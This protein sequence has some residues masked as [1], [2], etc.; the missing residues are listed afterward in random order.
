MTLVFIVINFLLL[1]VIGFFHLYWGFGG[2]WPGRDEPSLAKAVIGSNG[3]TAMP[4]RAITLIVSACLFLASIWPLI[5]LGLIETPLPL[6]IRELG[7][8]GLIVVFIGRGIAG[9]VPSFRRKNSELPFANYDRQYYSPLCFMIGVFFG[10][11]FF[12]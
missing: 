8:I 1:S 6:A 2:M 9:Y 3:I 11:I 7:M 10:A 12:L 4:P 5:W